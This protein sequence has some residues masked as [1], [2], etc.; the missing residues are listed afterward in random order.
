MK[1]TSNKVSQTN[2]RYLKPVIG[3]ERPTP[4]TLQKG[5]YVILKCRTVPG[6]AKSPTYDLPIPYFKT[7]SPEE[8]LNWR[9]SLDKAMIGQDCTTAEAK[10]GMARRLLDGDALAAF[11]QSANSFTSENLASFDHV[12]AELTAHVF[13]ARAGQ[14]QKRYMRRFMKKPIGMSIKA[15]FARFVEIN[16][17]FVYFPPHPKT[18]ADVEKFDSDELLDILEYAIP[19]AWK[20]EML[21]QD[22]DPVVSTLDAF[23]AFCERLEITL[24]HQETE[25]KTNKKDQE[26]KHTT[27][28]KNRESQNNADDKYCTLHGKGNHSTSECFTLKRKANKLKK[29]N[30]DKFR[31]KKTNEMMTILNNVVTKM[32]TAGTK[33]QQAVEEE[34][35]NF[36][37]LTVSS[38]DGTNDLED[39]EELF[40]NELEEG[41]I[42]SANSDLHE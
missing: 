42:E 30:P 40:N 32:S 16:E 1:T 9:K 25:K 5:E 18:Q 31:G 17:L 37:N 34:I 26:Q 10:Y 38:D 39:L 33:S 35:K 13:P 24:P 27:K 23:T 36:E 28:R 14:T 29:D 4:V 7:G 19:F 21:L 15:F 11:N 3:L 12:I 20:R 41:E 6:D 22:F 8:F 2:R